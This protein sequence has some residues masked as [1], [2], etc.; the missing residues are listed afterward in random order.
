M[1]RYRSRVWVEA[2][3][4]LYCGKGDIVITSEKYSLLTII[5]FLQY[6]ILEDILVG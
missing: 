5:Y 2:V 1:E 6:L 3:S 4:K